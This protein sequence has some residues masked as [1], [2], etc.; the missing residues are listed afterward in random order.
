MAQTLTYQWFN[1]QNVNELGLQIAP[2]LLSTAVA[3]YQ[4]AFA[5]APWNECFSEE[6][7]IS[8]FTRLARTGTLGFAIC[9]SKAIG[10][11]GG[12]PYE[13]ESTYYIDEL[14]INP[15][16]QGKGYASELL[17]EFMLKIA[18]HVDRVVLRTS[19]RH[20]GAMGLYT[21]F[22]FAV[23][24]KTE[25]EY[26]LRQDGRIRLDERVYLCNDFRLNRVA[27][28]ERGGEVTAF[29]FDNCSQYNR[30]RLQA[31][32]RTAWVEKYDYD[33]TVNID[34]CCFIAL[35]QDPDAMTRLEFL[36]PNSHPLAEESCLLLMT[37]G[38]DYSGVYES[39]TKSVP[40]E[41]QDG[42]LVGG[43]GTKM[44]VLFDGRFTLY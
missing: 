12:Y 43:S 3:T 15:S 8:T 36:D 25:M 16:C 38:K 18:A 9:E 33:Q 28:I 41:I 23:S 34:H 32:I 29:V 21:K 13:N 2:E 37:E 1:H 27:V 11:V 31:R 44:R 39:G 30:H 17:Q 10:L 5:E 20:Q 35:P 14:A 22:G 26:Q 42:H 24:G 6:E 7:V 40:F 19:A 4:A